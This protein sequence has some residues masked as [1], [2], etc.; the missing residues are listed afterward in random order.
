MSSTRCPIP[1][2]PRWL[3]AG[4]ALPFLIIGVLSWVD[5]QARAQV[6]LA[7]LAYERQTGARPRNRVR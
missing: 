5:W 1:V 6:Q 7:L 3:G 4:G 2:W